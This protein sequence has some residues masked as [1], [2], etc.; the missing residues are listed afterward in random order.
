[1]VS[2]RHRHRCLLNSKIIKKKQIGNNYKVSRG[3]VNFFFLR[4]INKNYYFLTIKKE[5]F[6]LS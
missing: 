1:M 5:E 2:V 4:I 6:M 3:R